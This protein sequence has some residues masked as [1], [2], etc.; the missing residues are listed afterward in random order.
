MLTPAEGESAED[1]TLPM[2]GGV[3]NVI[4]DDSF[5]D[6]LAM[7]LEENLGIVVGCAVGG[8]VLIAVG[9]ILGVVLA[10]RRRMTKSVARELRHE[11]IVESLKRAPA[12]KESSE[13]SSETEGE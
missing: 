9:A 8:I 3:Q 11:R 2:T 13:E 4:Y 7:A 5:S 6:R 12:E 1:A 10:R